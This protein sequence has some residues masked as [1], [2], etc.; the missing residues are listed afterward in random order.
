RAA[1]LAALAS[2]TLYAALAGFSVPTRRA[3]IMVAVAMGVVLLQLRWRR[4]DALVLALWGVLLWDPLSVMEAGF[5]LSFAAVA[6]ILY[7]M[8]GQGERRRHWW[9]R[10]R[11]HG[12]VALGL[13]PLSL[14]FFQQQPL[15]APVANLVAVPWVS[16]LVVP[17][18]LAGALCLPWAPGTGQFL[19]QGGADLLALLWPVLEHLAAWPAVRWQHAPPPWS[20][21]V[22]I[23]G[24]GLLLAPRGLPGRWLGA[25]WLLPL[26]FSL[27]PSPAPGSVRFTL[28][29]VGQGL[30]A[31]LQ[32]RHHVLVY[33]TGPRY[34]ASFDA[35]GAV[36][37]PF[38]RSQGVERVNLLIVGH[39]DNDH[40]GG[41]RSLLR[42][43]PVERILSSVPSR[44]A[45]ARPCHAGQAWQWDGVSFR[46]LHP[47]ADSELD[48][49]DAS[50]VLHV[51]TKGPGILLTGDIEKAAERALLRREGQ[52]LRA[53][54]LVAP[55]HGSRTSSSEPF[56]DAVA[57]EH[58]L[59]PVGYRNRYRLPAEAVVARYRRLGARLW[60]SARHGAISV[61]LDAG[62]GL[63]PPRA[64]R[65]VQ[66]RYWHG[67]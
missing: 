64:H 52:W 25:L 13:A 53:R 11:L 58:V 3:L 19:L 34:S 63:S 50:C 66:R 36:L 41:A 12:A 18:V 26:F 59:F 5:W 49:N 67:G 23:A 57:P 38:L 40:L 16:L 46:M 55:H 60:D 51:S 30:A 61:V 47:G 39:G 6:V 27:P 17:M 33:D 22:S 4:S 7:A 62:G 56:I 43:M 31:V 10:G 2:A 9:R 42:E 29:D 28:L 37:V 24:L 1:A 35:G 45:G 65:L 8:G 44:L 15:L 20:A 14:L 54:L 21:A 32:T 48:G